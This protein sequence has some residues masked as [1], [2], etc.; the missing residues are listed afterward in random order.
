MKP[1]FFSSAILLLFLVHAN[2]QTFSVSGQVSD[3]ITH[4][5]ISGATVFINKTTNF[6]YTDSTGRFRFDS[7]TN[8]SATIV[9]YKKDYQL[10]EYSVSELSKNLNI[11]FVIA[12]EKHDDKEK[13]DSVLAKESKQWQDTFLKQF[14]GESNNAYACEVAN[15]HVIRYNYLKKE[16]KLLVT[17]DEP[18][19]IFN[20]NTGYMITYLLDECEI[21]FN[22]NYAYWQGYVFF[23]PLTTK[24]TLTAEEWRYNRES[25]YLGSFMH[26]IRSAVNNK[27]K[28]EGFDVSFYTRLYESDNRF[29]A[30]IPYAEYK[31]L[32]MVQDDKGK[33]LF[34][35]YIDVPMNIKNARDSL[36]QPGA[37]GYYKFTF[38]HMI[39]RVVYKRFVATSPY[40]TNAKPSY[41]NLIKSDYPVS[42]ML[43]VGDSDVYAEKNGNSFPENSILLQGYWRWLRVSDML[44]L[45]YER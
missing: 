37:S 10:S 12:E 27:L 7:L 38:N 43:N 4:K 3:S 31:G 30:L 6:A 17:A 26:F 21:D 42:L 45:N 11:E 1:V 5:A 24:S 33:T 35:N 44:P 2:A 40:F 34:A 20:E 22:N 18:L 14:L 32:E 15:T 19:I 13:P 39:V 9:C 8:S 25:A 16:N 36:I 23:K 28:S 41:A 29:K